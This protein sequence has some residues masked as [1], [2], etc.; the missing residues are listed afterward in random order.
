MLNVIWILNTGCVSTEII[1]NFTGYTHVDMIFFFYSPALK[2]FLSRSFIDAKTWLTSLWCASSALTARI[3][4]LIV[5]LSGS[6]Q[7]CTAISGAGRFFH[8]GSRPASISSIMW[9]YVLT[10]SSSKYPTN[11]KI[12]MKV[13]WSDW[14]K[15]KFKVIK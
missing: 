13:S 1:L 7:Y 10:A 8:I 5:W 9:L 4:S 2:G 12:K 15:M 11:L 6:C 3:T 14:K